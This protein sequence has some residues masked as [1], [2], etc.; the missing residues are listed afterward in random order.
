RQFH[1][2]IFPPAHRVEFDRH[3]FGHH[4]HG[5][6]PFRRWD[7]RGKYF[8]RRSADEDQHRHA[9]SDRQ[10]QLYRRHHGERRHAAR[11]HEQP[12]RQHR[13]QRGRRLQPGRQRRLRRQHVGP[14]HADEDRRRHAD[15]RRHQHLHGRYG[16]FSGY[17][18]DRRCGAPRGER[19]WQRHGEQRRAA[20]GPWQHHRQAPQR[21]RHGHAGRQH[22]HAERRRQLHARR[23]QHLGDRGLA[24]RGLATPGRRQRCARRHARPHF[25]S[26]RLYRKDLR[27]REGRRRHRHFRDRDQ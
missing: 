23:D 11:Q 9:D 27:A 8:R 18:G 20:D 2:A 1:A 4:R 22:R 14:R 10:Q 19:F 16:G 15:S 12:A 24:E 25:R 17:A 7:T 5:R 13:Q 6:Y 21:R 26:G 3:W